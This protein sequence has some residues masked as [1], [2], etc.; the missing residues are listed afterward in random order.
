MPALQLFDDQTVVVGVGHRAALDRLR[1]T[2][3]ERQPEDR[4]ALEAFLLEDSKELGAH[5]HHARDEGLR[6][7]AVPGG[8]DCAVHRFESLHGGEK[9]V[10]AP[11]LVLLG[12]LAFQPVAEGL[13]VGLEGVRRGHDFRD[14]IFGEPRG[15]AERLRGVRGA[16]ATIVL[17]G[18]SRDIGGR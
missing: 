18:W 13:V 10:L 12:E 2:P 5:E 6:R 1:R 14:A 15:L 7:V 9:Q 4:D 8:L 11:L 16:A 3:V 17:V